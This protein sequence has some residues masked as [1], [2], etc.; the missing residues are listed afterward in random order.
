ME[1]HTLLLSYPHL[2]A[3]ESTKI[4]GTSHDILSTTRHLEYWRDDL[5]MLNAASIRELR[6]PVPWHRIESNFGEWDWEWID[7][8]LNLMRRLG[9]CPI[10]DPLHHVS[11]PDWLEHGFANAQFPELYTRFVRKVAERYPWADRY[12]V[13]NEP[14]PTTILCAHMGT[15]HPYHRS[16]A[17]FVFMATNVARAICLASAQLRESNPQIEL[18]HIDSCEHHQALDFES[19]PFVEHANHRRF[20]FSD[21]IL[22]KVRGSHPLLPYLRSYGFDTDQQDWF[23]DHQAKFDVLGLDYYAHSEI[24][25]RW[26]A[27]EKRALINFPC[28]HPRGFAEVAADY[29]QQY[30][31][32][33]M[34]SETNIGGTPADRLT[35]LKFMEQ[36]AEK[37][38]R[39]ADFRGFCWFP[40]IDATDWSSLCTEA[41]L[42]LSPMG[43]WSLDASRRERHSSL[44][45]EWYVR[46]AQGRASSRDLPAYRFAAPL[47]QDLRGF[48][49]LMDWP[50]WRYAEADGAGALQES[51]K[52]SF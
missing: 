21:L 36:E 7:G 27:G 1:S 2:G 39:V 42:D 48:L 6:Y 52:S 14:L 3:F 30:R 16:D 8:P 38:S 24:D 29:M 17:E 50:D 49:P 22:G 33:V 43:I 37:L 4:F 15:W 11:L 47:D 31:T 12:T 32:P 19:E 35:W 13:V 25:W 46:L 44:L 10:L 40:S 20:L 5:E 45:S 18:V 23:G 34:L 26:D 51:V 28:G 41:R 9:M